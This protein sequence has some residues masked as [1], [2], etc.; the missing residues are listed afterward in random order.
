MDMFVQL[1]ANGLITGSGYILIALGMSL[2]FGV[3]DVVN[4]AHGMF[5]ALGA[6]AL[7]SFTVSL[8]WNYWFAMFITMLV[9][10]TFGFGG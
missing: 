4:V 1:A 9:M 6:Y 2:V 3:L 7:Y 10:A 5:Y 8:G